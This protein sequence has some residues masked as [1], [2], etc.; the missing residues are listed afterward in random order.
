MGDN[1]LPLIEGPPYWC[2]V[3]VGGVTY[4]KGK[5]TNKKEAKV[6]AAGETMELFLPGALSQLAPPTDITPSGSSE[7]SL[8]V[9]VC[10]CVCV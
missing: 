7:D 5:G 8:Q 4:G 9:C 2:E 6:M 10:V 3:K 1:Y